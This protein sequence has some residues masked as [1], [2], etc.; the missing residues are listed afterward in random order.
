MQ[1]PQASPPLVLQQT[2]PYGHHRAPQPPEQLLENLRSLKGLRHLSLVF[3]GH[4]PSIQCI[5]V[6]QAVSS[7]QHLSFLEL[8]GATHSLG[9]QQQQQHQK[10][11]QQQCLAQLTELRQLKLEAPYLAGLEHL[12]ALTGL[13]LGRYEFIIQITADDSSSIGRLTNLLSLELERCQLTTSAVLRLTAL[14]ALHI[15]EVFNQ[16]LHVAFF[17]WLESQP[18]AV[19][20]LGKMPGP[21]GEATPAAAWAAVTVSSALQQLDLSS[22]NPPSEAWQHIFPAGRQLLQLTSLQLPLV[23]RFEQVKRAECMSLNEVEALVQCCPALV[24]LEGGKV[25]SLE[26]A[27]D[28][29][30]ALTRLGAVRGQRKAQGAALESLPQLQEVHLTSSNGRTEWKGWD[31]QPL[32]WLPRLTRLELGIE[33]PQR[34]FG[35][36]AYYLGNLVSLQDLSGPVLTEKQLQGLT[37]LTNLT[38]LVFDLNQQ[39]VLLVPRLVRLTPSNHDNAKGHFCIQVCYCRDSQ[40]HL[41]LASLA[42]LSPCSRMDSQWFAHR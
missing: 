14:T 2:F 6:L 28:T 42:Q 9:D 39:G 25:L 34:L 35:D 30:T 23:G 16:G 12:Q 31:F 29:L 5:R 38:S 22:A 10:Q 26:P 24:Q 36:A 33:H 7:L 8:L 27:L 13:S 37:N 18:L 21:L 20:S 4:V 17:P 11:Q 1:W 32:L 41:L 19:L 15:Q 40:L 3:T